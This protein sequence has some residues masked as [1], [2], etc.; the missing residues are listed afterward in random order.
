MGKIF[1]IFRT[2]RKFPNFVFNPSLKQIYFIKI[3][4]TAVTK[5]MKIM[6]IGPWLQQFRPDIRRNLAPKT[7]KSQ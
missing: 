5:E 4:Q 3:F 2:K 6:T 7:E 1:E